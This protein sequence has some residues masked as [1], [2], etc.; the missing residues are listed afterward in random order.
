[1][2]TLYGCLG[3]GSVCGQAILAFVGAEHKVIMLNVESGEHLQNNYLAMNPR[4]QVPWLVTSDGSVISESIAIALHLADSFPDSNLIGQL[5]SLE[6]AQTYKWLAFLAT[7]IYEGVLR[8]AHSDRFTTADPLDVKTKAQSDIDR[9][10]SIIEQSFRGKKLLTG[11]HINVADIYM[12][13]LATWCID[14]NKLQSD[15]PHL[16]TAISIVLNETSI[17]NIFSTNNLI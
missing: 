7:N 6:R 10:W 16:S 5:G 4:G 1:M 17:H 15:Y 9:W 8:I 14:N 2:Y 11:E 3:T 13:M 12:T